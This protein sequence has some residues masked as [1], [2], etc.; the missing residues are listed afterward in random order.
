MLE[1]CTLRVKGPGCRVCACAKKTS[2]MNRFA[3]VQVIRVGKRSYIGLCALPPDNQ[4]GFCNDAVGG[5]HDACE[6]HQGAF[7]YCHTRAGLGS[8][9][10][11]ADH[12]IWM[13]TVGNITVLPAGCSHSMAGWF[14]LSVRKGLGGRPSCFRFASETFCISNLFTVP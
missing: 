12:D 8:K 14:S 7:S 6:N 10:Q 13:D 9:N 3:C 5:E 4:T 11:E 2:T 1:W